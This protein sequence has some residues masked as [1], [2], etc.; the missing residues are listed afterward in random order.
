MDSRMYRPLFSED[1]IEKEETMNGLEVRE[2][3]DKLLL[4]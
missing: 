4:M 2:V 3:A 1:G